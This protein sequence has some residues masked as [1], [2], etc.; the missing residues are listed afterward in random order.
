MTAPAIAKSRDGEEP[1][2]AEVA[3]GV[4]DIGKC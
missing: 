2:D 1:R 3:I 4:R